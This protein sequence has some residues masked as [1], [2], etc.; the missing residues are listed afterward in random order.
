MVILI[1]IIH[2][3]VCA[4]LILVVLLQSGK[5]GDLASAF[6]GMG[7]QAAF[8]PRGTA[9]ALSKATTGAAVVFMLTSILLAVMANRAAGVGSSVLESAPVV[10]APATPAPAPTPNLPTTPPQRLQQEAPAESAPAEA[11]KQ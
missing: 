10:E 11:P 1:T 2:V 8:G 3:L 5:A 6:G 9:T 4:F 7:S